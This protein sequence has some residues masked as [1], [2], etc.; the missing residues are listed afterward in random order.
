MATKKRAGASATA[1]MIEMPGGSTMPTA[2]S[3]TAVSSPLLVDLGK[4][5]RKLIKQLRRGEG[6]L[7]DEVNQ[8]VQELQSNGTLTDFSQPIVVL[9]REKRK[10]MGYGW[11]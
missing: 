5:K 4:K 10:R 8:T 1:V 9:V 11:F 3:D 2:T 6:K 7:M